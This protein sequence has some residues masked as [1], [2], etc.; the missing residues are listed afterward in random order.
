MFKYFHIIKFLM[1]HDLT[2]LKECLEVEF[3]IGEFSWRKVITR[4]IKKKQENYYFWWRLANEMFRNGSKKQKRIATNIQTRLIRQYNVEIGLG[5]TI[6][7]GLK[8]AH[9]FAIIISPN[10]V[11]GKNLFIHQCV[12]IGR[13]YTCGQ[14]KIKINDNVVI[15]SNSV[16]IG[17]N[18]KIGH[19]VII[20]AMSFINKNIPDN[21]TVY[22][23]K[24]NKILIRN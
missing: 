13:N 4:I 21:C 12:T 23:E 16:I 1:T 7:Y 11:I 19:N 14:D 6:D 17:G 18:I 10:V 15:C 20:G 2:F 9:F 22:T 3:I 24:N 8:I 5:A